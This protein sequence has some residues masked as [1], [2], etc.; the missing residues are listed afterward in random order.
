MAEKNYTETMKNKVSSQEIAETTL[1]LIIAYI[2]SINLEKISP[3][4]FTEVFAF[5][6]HEIDS[7]LFLNKISARDAIADALLDEFDS[8][9][10]KGF[11]TMDLT[12]AQS[13]FTK[14]L[15]EYAAMTRAGQEKTKMI[16]LFYSNL[17][18]AIKDSKAAVQNAPVVIGTLGQLQQQPFSTY[19]FYMANIAPFLKNILVSCS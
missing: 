14:R 17:S 1:S 12:C 8:A 15:N 5:I 2:E 16:D 4:I 3:S 6:H 19:A 10:E 7:L 13:L 11:T 9:I 18:M